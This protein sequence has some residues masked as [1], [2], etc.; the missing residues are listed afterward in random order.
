LEELIEAH[1]SELGDLEPGDGAAQV[2]EAGVEEGLFGGVTVFRGGGE[3]E[4]PLHITPAG[5]TVVSRKRHSCKIDM[6][7]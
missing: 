1:V 3:D 2:A 6:P 4:A 7:A 5:E